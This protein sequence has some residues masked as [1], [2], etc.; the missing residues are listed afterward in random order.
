MADLDQAIKLKP[1]N[2]PA[3][4]ERAV[5]YWR[6]NQPAQARADLEAAAA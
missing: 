4:V 5:M 6:M 3:L 1:D 2:I